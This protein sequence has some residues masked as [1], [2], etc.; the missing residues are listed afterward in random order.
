M[1][2]VSTRGL[3]GV[4]MILQE[5]F[6]SFF[7]IHPLL[8]S[9]DLLVGTVS[10]LW[11]RTIPGDIMPNVYGVSTEN[12]KVVVFSLSNQFQPVKITIES[13]PLVITLDCLMLFLAN[14]AP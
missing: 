14:F 11:Q 4:L 10:F 6:T 2:D 3:R 5:I 13:S 7:C 8:S 9:K 1:D 12:H